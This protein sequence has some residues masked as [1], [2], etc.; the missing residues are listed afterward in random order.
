MNGNYAITI[1]API[2]DYVDKLTVIGSS[3]AVV[4]IDLIVRFAVDTSVQLGA[5]YER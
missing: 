2:F 5:M 1:I 4:S 3:G